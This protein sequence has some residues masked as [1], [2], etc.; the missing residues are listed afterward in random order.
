MAENARA[1]N[2]QA[3]RDPNRDAGPETAIIVLTQGR[4]GQ[5]QGA[6]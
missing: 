2:A 1:C 5:S 3:L 4:Y 6:I